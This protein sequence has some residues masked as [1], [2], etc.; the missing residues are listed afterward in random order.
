MQ[1]FVWDDFTAKPDAR[2]RICVPALAGPAEEPRPQRDRRWRS[3]SRTEPLFSDGEHDVFFNRGVA[4]SQ[5]YERRFGNKSPTD[6][7]A[8]RQKESEALQWLSRDL[9]EALLK[10]IDECEEGRYAARLLLRIPL[11]AGRRRR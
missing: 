11:L 2:I 5:A 3:R 6:Q 9:D 8:R 4:S 10:F 7:L 1:S